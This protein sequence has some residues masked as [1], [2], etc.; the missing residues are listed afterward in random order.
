MDKRKARRDALSVLQQ[1][2]EQ[3]ITLLIVEECPGEE[4]GF[5]FCSP[6]LAYMM[7]VSILEVDEVEKHQQQNIED[8]YLGKK[9][10]ILLF[11]PVG[12]PEFLPLVPCGDL[13]VHHNL[14][15]MPKKR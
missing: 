4:C 2:R 9:K 3:L 14:S 5:Y 8:T 15:H 6:S 12:S 7:H 1:C 13:A 11:F 10:E